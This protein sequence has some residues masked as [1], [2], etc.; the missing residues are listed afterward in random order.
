MNMLNPELQLSA[1]VFADDILK[2]PT[3][4]GFGAGVVEAGK[5]DANVVVL[6]ADLKESTRAE[7]FEKAFPERFVEMGVAEQNMA[8]VAA[9]MAAVGKIPF[10]ASYA[11]FSPGRNYEQIRTTIAL[12]D[13]P[14]KVCGMHAGIS[15]GPD[16]ATHQM[17]EDIALMRAMP[18]MTVIV[19]ADAEEARKAVIAAATSGTP[20]YLR[21][22][23]AGTPVFTTP[24]TPFSIG[25]ALLLWD[26][27][28]PKVALLATGSLSYE[29]LLAARALEAEGI[30]SVV[31]HIPTVK[32][33][34][35]AAVVSAASRAG[36]VITIE[37]HQVMGGFGS[38]VA[39]CLAEHHPVPMRFIGMHDEFGQ[40]GEPQ[41]LLTHYKLDA[42]AI[43]DAARH[44]VRG[45]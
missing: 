4:D 42:P 30:E 45:A 38:A 15:V 19:P 41:Q 33:L 26:S 25:K 37:E 20:V 13:V 28:A 12:N 18:N 34:D 27:K 32:P 1:K 2:K 29:A 9:G 5:Q 24:E 3:R 6:C 36:R 22:G 44:L 14:V 23:R 35:V 39:E 31:L 11:A 43:V 10:I 21:F 17:L 16:G 7:E 8:T 40:S